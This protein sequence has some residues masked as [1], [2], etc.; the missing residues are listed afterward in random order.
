MISIYNTNNSIYPSHQLRFALSISF[1][2]MALEPLMFVP[3]QIIFEIT[4]LLSCQNH[5]QQ[6]LHPVGELHSG[7]LRL[8]DS[9]VSVMVLNAMEEFQAI[10][11]FCLWVWSTSKWATFSSSGGKPRWG[12]NEY[13]P[14]SLDESPNTYVKDDTARIKCTLV[15]TPRLPAP[16]PALKPDVDKF[17]GTGNQGNPSGGGISFGN[18]FHTESYASPNA[19]S[20]KYTKLPR[21]PTIR[22]YCKANKN[23]S[24]T[25]RNGTAVLAPA[26]SNDYYQVVNQLIV[27]KKW[28]NTQSSAGRRFLTILMFPIN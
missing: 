1:T 17:A 19:P 14:N 7:R 25:A 23:L 9:S 4:D 21:Q 28:V 11:S 3:D 26:N 18:G 27:V 12:Y 20:N 2:G 10:S 6:E 16:A 5:R 13:L 22:I 15:V 24:V 8:A